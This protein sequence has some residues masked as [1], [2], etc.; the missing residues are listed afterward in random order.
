[1]AQKFGNLALMKQAR[2]FQDIGKPKKPPGKKKPGR[3]KGRFKLGDVTEVVVR[4][5]PGKK[6][7]HDIFLAKESVSKPAS[8]VV[9]SEFDTATGLTAIS[10]RV[11]GAAAGAEP[12][13]LKGLS[14]VWVTVKGPL[15]QMETSALKALRGFS[16]EEIYS[17]VVPKRTLARRTA[18]KQPLSAE[19]T[20]RAVRLARVGKMAEQV[21]G[22]VEKAHRWLRKPKPS[23][24][25]ETPLNYLASETGARV[26]EEMLTRIDHGILP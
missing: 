17:L 8:Y 22:S 25:G 10:D 7:T 19:E 1:L 15:V 18:E 21:F 12:T 26:V 16:D 5:G 3:S 13:P 24:D 4:S 6:P 14:A 11:Y 20:D 2:P 9:D 23:L